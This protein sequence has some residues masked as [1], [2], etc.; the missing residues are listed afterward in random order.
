MFA[1][2]CVLAVAH[3]A[4]DADDHPS[5][6]TV[7]RTASQI[8]YQTAAIRKLLIQGSNFCASPELTFQPPLALN[9]DYKI[10]RA[11][12]GQLTLSLQKHKKWRYE[13][14]PL[15]LTALKCGSDA[16]ELAYGQGIVVAT[17]LADPTIEMSER[18]CRIQPLVWVVLTKLENSLARS[19]RSRF[20]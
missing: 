4:V 5:G 9:S 7:T 18:L 11:Q 12:A 6:L 19:N 16:I 10:T 13:A 2:A 3:V 20:G 15:Y 14:G 17:V 1:L 8:L